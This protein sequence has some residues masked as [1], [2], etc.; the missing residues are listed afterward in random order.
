MPGKGVERWVNAM[1]G[2]FTILHG[3]ESEVNQLSAKTPQMKSPQTPSG[4]KTHDLPT[5][6]LPFE[7]LADARDIV[8]S[9]CPLLMNATIR[10]KRK[11]SIQNTDVRTIV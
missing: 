7:I 5:N 1:L 11:C 8:N 9:Y 4:V 6:S 2:I 10:T 3:P